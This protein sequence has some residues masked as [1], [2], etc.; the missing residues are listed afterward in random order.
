MPASTSCP[1][2]DDCRAR[3]GFDLGWTDADWLSTKKVAYW[4]DID[5]W[6]LQCLAA[7][8]KSIRHLDPLLMSSE[9]FSQFAELAVPEPVVAGNEL[10]VDLTQAEKNLYKQLLE[11][12]CGRLEQEFLPE[13]LCRDNNSKLGEGFLTLPFANSIDLSPP[14]DT[15]RNSPSVN[16]RNQRPTWNRYGRFEGDRVRQ[17]ERERLTGVAGVVVEAADARQRRR[18]PLHVNQ[19]AELVG[20]R[21]GQPVG[22]PL[23]DPNVVVAGAETGQALRW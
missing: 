5:T 2:A 7:A 20:Q 1:F 17:V 14:V 4:G 22:I 23:L 21:I 6:G 12:P 18:G 19:P 3:T 16:R 10:P 11:E 13:E 8:R 9:V 15:K